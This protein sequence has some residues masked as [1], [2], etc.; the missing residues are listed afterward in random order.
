MDR[1]GWLAVA[2][3]GRRA[4]PTVVRHREHRLEEEP[5]EAIIQ[6]C[7]KNPKGISPRITL[8]SRPQRAAVAPGR[9]GAAYRA[10]AATCA[11]DSLD[12]SHASTSST[13][14]G[15]R[16]DAALDLESLCLS[17]GAPERLA[18]AGN[19]E[20]ASLSD[21]D[22]ADSDLTGDGSTEDEAQ[23]IDA[24]HVVEL[25]GFEGS[26]QVFCEVCEAACVTEDG[27]HGGSIARRRGRLCNVP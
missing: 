11:P 2:G 25:R 10:A 4:Q 24:R 15:R 5:V 20:L 18:L 16:Q 8:L 17:G 21:R 19:R 14:A 23:G 7:I 26:S 9:A 6:A 13:R 22:D 27:G 3:L 12:A 1:G